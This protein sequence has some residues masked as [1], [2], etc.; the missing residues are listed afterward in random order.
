[1]KPAGTKGPCNADS[2]P[3]DSIWKG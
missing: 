1:M 2:F 3:L